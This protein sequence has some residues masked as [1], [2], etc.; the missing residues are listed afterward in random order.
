MMKRVK[1]FRVL[2]FGIMFFV[3]SMGLSFQS[4]VHAAGTNYKT[5]YKN[6][7]KKNSTTVT[8]KYKHGNI[9]GSYKET[10]HINFFN[11]IDIDK[12]GVKE[13]VVEGDLYATNYYVFGIRKGKVVFLGEIRKGGGDKFCY[14]PSAKGLVA[15]YGGSG[16]AGNGLWRIRKGK[17]TE[18]VELYAFFNRVTTFELNYKKCSQRVYRS[19]FNKYFKPSKLKVYKFVEKNSKNIKKILR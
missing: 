7:L 1:C 13:L 9:K 5:I 14:N 11:L 19:Y 12:N 10:I 15:M 16:A 2:L 6:F 17:L 18:S 3:L 8:V 4:D